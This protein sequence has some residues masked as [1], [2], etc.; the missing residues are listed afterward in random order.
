MYSDNLMLIGDA[1]S[2]VK[3]IS[4]GGIY[5]TM[6]CVEPLVQTAKEALSSGDLSA[7]SL[8][9]YEKK[10]SR[11]VGK[12]LDRAYRLRK[13]YVKFDNDDMDDIYPYM[14]KKS[15][16]DALNTVDIDN[17]SVSALMALRN[18][19]TAIKVARIALRAK[20]RR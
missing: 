3:P 7:R 13:I 11:T 17:P 5:P 8:S 10:W 9:R 18:I 14:A 1:A 6:M 4:A 19:P 15:V 16:N 12:E 2:Q 20:G